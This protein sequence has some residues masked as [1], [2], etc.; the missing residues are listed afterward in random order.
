M[1]RVQTARPEDFEHTARLHRAHLKLGLFP[2]LGRSFLARYQQTFLDSPHGIALVARTEDGEI[3]GALFGTT[4]N[5]DHYRW[6]VRNCGHDLAFAGC[7]ALV[8][9]PSLAW[10]FAR[11]RLGRYVRGLI[12]HTQSRSDGSAKPAQSG[13]VSVL[14]HIVIADSARR[15]G[16]GRQ[17]VDAFK[18]RARTQGA[19]RAVLITQEGGLGAPFFEKIGCSFLARRQ[20]Q[21]GS[22]VRE[23]TLALEEPR[24]NATLAAFRRRRR[25]FTGTYRPE[26]AA[27]A[28][29]RA[30]IGP[31]DAR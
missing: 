3:V 19:R 22:A 17:L 4:S 10:S 6:V 31:I 8:M 5:P 15:R 14:S 13:P 28:R 29:N 12:R 11:T 30:A 23:Y 20:S 2:K 7:R 16:I 26:L 18:D 24:P 25:V 9:R 1:L 27:I 21:D